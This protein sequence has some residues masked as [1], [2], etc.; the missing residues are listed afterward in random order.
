MTAPTLAQN[1][2]QSAEIYWLWNRAEAPPEAVAKVLESVRRDPVTRGPEALRFFR[3]ARPDLAVA[4]PD[5]DDAARLTWWF[6][7]FDICPSNGLAETNTISS[8]SISNAT[9][10]KT[11]RR[12]VVVESDRGSP[13]VT[14]SPSAVSTIARPPRVVHCQ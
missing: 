11:H 8:P 10:A 7:R 2:L 9:D 3:R 14:F 1:D 13:R 12:H 6:E 4:E 5:G